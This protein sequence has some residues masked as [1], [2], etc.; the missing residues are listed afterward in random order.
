M[1]LRYGLDQPQAADRI[2]QAV[3][4]VLAQGYRTGDIYAPGT[5][6]VGCQAMGAVLIDALRNGQD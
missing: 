5:T 2:E 1:M 3:L 4:S 6:K